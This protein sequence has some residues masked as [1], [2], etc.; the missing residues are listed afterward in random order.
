[1]T[2][3]E[4]TKKIIHQY[5]KHPENRSMLTDGRCRYRNDEGKMCA[6]TYMVKPDSRKKL[7]ESKGCDRLL[8]DYNITLDDI[9]P[10]FIPD[11]MAFSI[12]KSFYVYLQEIHDHYYTKDRITAYINSRFIFTNDE[13]EELINYIETL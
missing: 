9:Q 8:D 7:I 5:V 13:K 2:A 6:F 11:D 4:I 1:M 3:I 12:L 10:E